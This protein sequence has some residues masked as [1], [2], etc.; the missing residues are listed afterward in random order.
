MILESIVELFN[1][2]PEA[3]NIL[4]IGGQKGDGLELYRSGE[5]CDRGNQPEYQARCHHH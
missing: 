2:D 3:G 1:M 4:V 5:G